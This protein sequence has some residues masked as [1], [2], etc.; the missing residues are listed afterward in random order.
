MRTAPS[1]RGSRRIF[2]DEL[3][4]SANATIFAMPFGYCL[5]PMS[6]IS[7]MVL[8]ISFLCAFLALRIAATRLCSVR[9]KI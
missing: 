4:F 8:G 1:I 6:Q 2:S 3:Q 5:L 9:V 7:I